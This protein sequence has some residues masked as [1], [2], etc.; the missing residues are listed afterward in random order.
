MF[1]VSALLDLTTAGLVWIGLS[2]N[3]TNPNV[4]AWSGDPLLVSYFS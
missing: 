3:D 1:F 4:L 2:L